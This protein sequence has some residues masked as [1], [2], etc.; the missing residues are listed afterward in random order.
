MKYLLLFGALFW[1]LLL[2]LFVANVY[3]PTSVV[4]FNAMFQS[5]IGFLFM[6]MSFD[7]EDGR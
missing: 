2:V 1:A 6:A 5:M 4:I 7:L 3:E